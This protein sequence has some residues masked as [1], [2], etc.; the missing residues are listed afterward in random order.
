MALSV[1]ISA[2]ISP[3]STVSPTLLSQLATV[4][5]S[6]VSLSLGIFTTITP[7]G[8]LV[9]AGAASAV[10]VE[11][12]SAIGL[13]SGPLASPDKRALISSPGSPIMANK[14]STGAAPP[15]SIPI[16]SNVP[17]LKDSNSIVAL[18]VSISARISPSEIASPTFF[19]HFATV[20]SS[21]VS[22]SLGIFTTIAI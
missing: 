21:M 10:G 11:L 6:I 17:S 5:S 13:N 22:L 8:R 4:P 16:C 2:K 19:N 1:S 18:S 3:S 12:V 20:P 7:S 15:S 9:A 14:E